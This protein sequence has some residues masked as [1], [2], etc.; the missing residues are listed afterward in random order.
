[1]AETSDAVY[2][3]A[4]G[5]AAGSMISPGIGTAIGAGLGLVGG[6]LQK[7]S[8]AKAAKAQMK[9]QE[10]MSNTAHQR[11]VADLRAAGLNPILSGTGGQGATTPSG[12]QPNVVPN[13]GEAAVNSGTKGGQMVAQVEQLQA[14]ATQARQQA[15][16]LSTE[17]EHRIA[18]LPR[19]KRFGEIY[20]DPELGRKAALAEISAKSNWKDKALSVALDPS[21]TVNSAKGIWNDGL[22]NLRE[23]FNQKVGEAYGETSGKAVHEALNPLNYRGGLGDPRTQSPRQKGE[24]YYVQPAQPG[25]NWARGQHSGGRIRR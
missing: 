22:K 5:A 17:N 6:F 3:A 21:A 24:D 20:S 18:D 7:S 13:L 23:R 4:E 25:D 15:A 8:S 14:S 2:G 19:A 11:E 10:R 12:A 1:M 9:F 16:V